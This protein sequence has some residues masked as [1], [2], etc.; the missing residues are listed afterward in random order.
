VGDLTGL[1]VAA[2]LDDAGLVERTFV[3]LPIVLQYVRL[4]FVPY[5]LSADY[6]PN[7]IQP[8]SSLTLAGGAAWSF[9]WS[10]SA[11]LG[12]EAQVP[13]GHLCPGLDGRKHS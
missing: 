8:A 2:G 5:R 6:N 4:L 3:M 10:R 13:R 7:F 11:R 12:H 1:E 9:C